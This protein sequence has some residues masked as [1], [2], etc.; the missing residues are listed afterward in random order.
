MKTEVTLELRNKIRRDMLIVK[1]KD[2]TNGDYCAILN[3]KNEEL[4]LFKE[5]VVWRNILDTYFKTSYNGGKL[6]KVGR[7]IGIKPVMIHPNS[8]E[9]AVAM[10]E[11]P[12]WKDWFSMEEE[13]DASKFIA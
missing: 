8:V 1:G 9:F 2:Y 11:E 4:Q 13:E 10:Y 3:F 12:S 7:F 6:H 5:C